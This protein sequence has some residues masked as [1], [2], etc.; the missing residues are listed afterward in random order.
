ME[1]KQSENFLIFDFETGGL[2]AHKNP[3]LEFAGIWVRSSDLTEICRYEAIIKP[4]Y[5]QGE[6]EVT[7]K[8]LEVNGLNLKEIEEGVYVKEVV[9]NI[10]ECCKK[11]NEGK[12]FKKCLPVGHNVDFDIAFLNQIFMASKKKDELSKCFSGKKD[13]FNNF[14][15][16]RFDTQYLSRARYANDVEKPAFDLHSACGYEEVELFDGHRA[17]N[18]V[19]A[20]KELFIQYLKYLRGSG[21]EADSQTSTFRSKFKFNF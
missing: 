19:I 18:D 15:P 20:T 16:A 3:A 2:S 7:P 10:I 13:Y 4:W 12:R 9:E 6:L 8:A 5:Q 1:N 11:A 21:T 17:M 14:N